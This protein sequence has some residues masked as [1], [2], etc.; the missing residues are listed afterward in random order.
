MLNTKVKH[1]CSDNGKEFSNKPFQKYFADNRIK[2]EFTNTYTLE[3][4]G[5]AESLN[6]NIVDRAHSILNESKWSLNFGQRLFCILPIYYTVFATSH[7]K[8]L[9]ELHCGNKPSVRHLHPF[10]TNAYIGVHRQLRK[11]KF[12]AKKDILVAYTMS[13]KG[14]RIWLPKSNK[15]I[16]TL[17][18]RFNKEATF[19]KEAYVE[20]EQGHAYSLIIDPFSVSQ[21]HN[22]SD[23]GPTYILISKP[24]ESRN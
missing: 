6:Q 5:V 22:R 16:E 24:P 23:L 19:P 4:N 17:N 7:S 9:F 8:T 12:K 10:G 20:N 14:Y 21:Q 15:I 3:Q 18:I 2:H 11:T 1:V 13:T